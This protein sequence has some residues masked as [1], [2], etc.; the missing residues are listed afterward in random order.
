[1]PAPEEPRSSRSAR[2]WTTVW[3]SLL[4]V[5]VVLIGVSFLLPAQSNGLANPYQA[6]LL[7]TALL[8]V[9]GVVVAVLLSSRAFR[10]S[11]VKLPPEL[12]TRRKE[13]AR[14]GEW[15]FIAGIV[16]FFIG[17]AG[18]QSASAAHGSSDIGVVALV[19]LA[20][21]IYGI[22]LDHEAGK[23]ERKLKLEWLAS[24]REKQG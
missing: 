10:L 20:M 17:A 8:C 9:V 12:E 13:A 15:W 14:K 6:L 22:V 5:A 1:M 21:I 23:F 16:L 4:G 3:V 7:I 2:R 19:G 11:F 18:Q 24:Q